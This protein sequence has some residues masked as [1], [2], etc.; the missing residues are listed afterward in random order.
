VPDLR[1]NPRAR[2]EDD[3]LLVSHTAHSLARRILEPL[4]L[5][6]IMKGWS[7]VR[8]RLADHAYR[9]IITCEK[10]RPLTGKLTGGA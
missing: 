1:G 3:L 7:I 5:P 6:H 10:M 4:I 8:K 2:F 9:V